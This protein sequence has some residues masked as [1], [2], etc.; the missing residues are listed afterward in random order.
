[1]ED[2]SKILKVEAYTMT[3]KLIISSDDFSFSDTMSYHDYEINIVIKGEIKKLIKINKKIKII[4]YYINGNREQYITKVDLCTEYQL[5]AMLRG[6]GVILKERRR[7]YKIKVDKQA[8]I[9]NVMNE[10]KETIIEDEFPVRIKDINI[11]GVLIQCKDNSLKKGDYIN[12]KMELCGSE[13]VLFAKVL[14]IQRLENDIQ[15]Y[16]CSFINTKNKDEEIIAKY[17]NQIQRERMDL[18]KLNLKKR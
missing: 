10:E 18:I 12:L 14:R 15:G 11:G 17:I 2:K 3:N 1:M 4:L 16:G 9:I 5:N 6:D 7:F 8:T 13:L